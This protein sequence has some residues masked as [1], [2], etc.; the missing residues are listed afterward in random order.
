MKIIMTAK[1]IYIVITQTKYLCSLGKWEDAVHSAR[2]AVVCAHKRMA[3]SDVYTSGPGSIRDI[4]ALLDGSTSLLATYYT[5]AVMLER[6]GASTEMLALEWYARVVRT[7]GK[8]VLK[9]ERAQSEID[10]ITFDDKQGV[11]YMYR[12]EIVY[13][14]I[15]DLSKLSEE[16]RSRLQRL[17]SQQKGYVEESKY[18]LQ[19]MFKSYV[20][21][22]NANDSTEK[23]QARLG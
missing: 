13:N 21:M 8:M 10:S 1:C 6:S 12:P 9:K 11:E 22:Y 16:A 17:P 18:F 20:Q 3:V 4:G 5:L 14:Q 7:A 2:L 23:T 19:S 15:N